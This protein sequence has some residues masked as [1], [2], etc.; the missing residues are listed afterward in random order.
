MT[1]LPPEG[2]AASA[3]CAIV[4]DVSTLQEVKSGRMFGGSVGN[5]LQR[6]LAEA[7]LIRSECYITN[8]I[9]D[10]DKPIQ[11]RYH[12]KSKTFYPEGQEYISALKAELELLD[13]KFIIA[14]GELALNALT[15]RQGI[16]KWRG[17]V[18][19]S[20][21][22]R[23][24]WVIPII[25]PN[26][27]PP[28]KRMYLNRYL[29]SFDLQR[30]ARWIKIGQYMPPDYSVKIRPTYFEILSYLKKIE[31]S[32]NMVAFDIE[33][34]NE[35]VSCISFA[36]NTH[37]AM[38]IPFI[39]NYG[40]M[41]TVNQELEI[42]KR[43]A[44]I[45]QNPKIQKLGQNLSFDVHFL[46]R[47]YGIA[48]NSMHDTMIAQQII[49]PDFKK[50][51]DFITSVHTDFQYHKDEGKKWFKVGGAWE[52][53]WNYNGLDS[54]V[55][56][57]AFPN[58]VN[59]LHNQQNMATYD[60]QRAIIEPLVY[61]QEHGIKA[62]MPG[63]TGALRDMEEEIVELQLKLNK[64]AGRKLNANSTPQLSKYLYGELGF[65]KYTK[66][67]S[68]T[69]DDLAMKRLIRKG[70]EEAKII[71]AIRKL[72][73]LSGTYLSLDKFDEDGRIRCSY[74]PVGTRYSRVSSSKNI[75][76]TG[77]NMQNWPHSLLMYL[78]ADE[79]M[80][81]YAMDLSQA[82]NRLV[83][84]VG[85][86]LP[87]IEAFEKGLDVHSITGAMIFGGTV[88]EI[89]AEANT[90]IKCTDI[91]DGTHTK[92]DW[93]KKANHGFNYGW[94]H[95]NFALKNEI[96]END[97]KFIFNKYHQT[98]PGVQQTYHKSVKRSLQ[99]DR[100]ITNLMG[101]KTLFLGE[102]TNK[103]YQEAY[104]C[105]PQ[106][107]VGD[108]IN[109]RGLSYVYYNTDLFAP[110]ELLNQVHDEI[111]FQIPA[112]NHPTTPCTWE[113]HATMLKLIKDSL[114]VP[115]TVHGRDF[116]IPVDTTVFLRM[117][118]G[119]DISST[120]MNGD[121]NTVSKLLETTFNKV[122]W[123]T[124]YLEYQPKVSI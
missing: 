18:I 107:T 70:C 20:T 5:V 99:T 6:C 32:C 74:D 55:C 100:T 7:D 91:G 104:S 73:K 41:F 89:K 92:R 93:G 15:S 112:P 98:Y 61:M 14:V 16:Y 57:V 33:V 79:F 81:G 67:G 46:L 66:K 64:L 96:P 68:V 39:N 56:M 47:K 109:E 72:R 63:I 23:G 116:V 34:Y 80:V 49:S 111:V 114:E 115:L 13:P 2:I 108:V 88:D 122:E 82:E 12:E 117:K 1:Y 36:H 28:P 8:V 53:L 22:I 123:N 19:E 9:K 59:E 62:D 52:Q 21:L 35:E 102:L 43:I 105:I 71:L 77:M 40:D 30:A 69:C 75:F 84:Q 65:S 4:G 103:T 121:L 17:S 94:Q 25:H 87:M 85:N 113:Q 42:W 76:E 119:I 44:R 101:R 118:R 24:K 48:T 45:L 29:I 3:K 120:A 58:Q 106:G 26:T 51:L 97:G 95:R 110:V 124:R 37:Y 11:S 31:D 50:G 83:A 86:I 54:L 78:M 27:V 90:K 38:S 60:R 10:I